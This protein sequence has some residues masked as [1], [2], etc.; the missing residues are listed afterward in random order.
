MKM[1]TGLTMLIDGVILLSSSRKAIALKPV[2]RSTAGKIQVRGRP[3][4][5]THR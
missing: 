5:P 1:V 3:E 2:K 4:F